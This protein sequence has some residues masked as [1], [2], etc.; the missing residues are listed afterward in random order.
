[1]K[2]HL[3]GLVAVGL[4]VG[5]V[6]TAKAQYRFST[7]DPPGSIATRA[8]GI[9]DS[10]QIVGL[11]NLDQ[12]ETHGFLL[13]RDSYTALD[14]PGSNYTVARGI[15]ASGQIVGFDFQPGGSSHGFLVSGGSFTTLD[16]PG[17]F[18][19]MAYGING[20]GQIVGKYSDTRQSH[21]FLLSG[22]TYTNLDLPLQPQGIND[23]GQ[24]VG[25]GYLLSGGSYTRI[26]VPGGIDTFAFGI[27]AAGE[28]VGSYFAGD[29][30]HAFLLSGNG[31]TTIDVPDSVQTAAYGIN[32]SGQ[33]V[34][35]YVDHGGVL[36]GFLA[37]PVP[38]PST[39]LL[40]A[41]GTL[42]MIVCLVRWVATT[43]RKP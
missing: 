5:G 1:M 25:G 29:R 17:S 24:I 39:L 14:V 27:N 43:G 13:S 34:G 35:D 42:G 11:Y 3:C 41:V 4:L 40:L 31:Y 26:D 30:F 28:I 8:Y 21:G 20:S 2:R 12:T 10:G 37:T 32:A 22:S 19:S 36:H 38:E 23:S 9:N 16:P 33:I 7:L 18:E 6:E 15:N